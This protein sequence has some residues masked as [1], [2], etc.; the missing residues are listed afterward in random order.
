MLNS[1]TSQSVSSITIYVFNDQ[2]SGFVLIGSFVVPGAYGY[3][4][5]FMVNIRMSPLLTKLGFGYQDVNGATTIVA[6]HI[7]YTAN[8]VV[9]LTF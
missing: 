5:P 4:S 3:G 6:K 9:D 1:T 7:D 2:P 8:V